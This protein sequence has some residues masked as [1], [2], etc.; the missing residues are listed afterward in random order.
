MAATLKLQRDIG[1]NLPELRRGP[2]TVVVDG[3]SIGALD[4]HESFE[5]EIVP[6]HHTLRLHRAATRAESAPSR[7]ATTTLPTSNATEPGLGSRG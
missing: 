1:P 2:F 3:K 5:E 7:L 4:N 6:G